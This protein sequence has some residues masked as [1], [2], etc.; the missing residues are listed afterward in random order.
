MEITDA[1]VAEKVMGWLPHFRN[2]AFYV[3]AEF[4][5]KICDRI[6]KSV[7]DWH[8]TTDI[9]Q[10]FRVVERMRNVLG[11]KFLFTLF[12]HKDGYG[13]T[14]SDGAY[15]VIADTP[16]MAIC[17]ASLAAIKQNGGC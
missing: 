5:G 16:A 13:C 1:M 17:E 6:E 14:F 3:K 12:S 8:P 9:S 4:A 7:L 15:D 11:D 2:S 10:A